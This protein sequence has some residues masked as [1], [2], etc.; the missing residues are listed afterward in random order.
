MIGF[1]DS[2]VGGLSIY[3]AVH[4][5]LPQ[6][7]TMYVG[8]NAHVPYGPRT[9][10][11]VRQFTTEVVRFL[12]SRNANPIIIACNTAS[13]ASLQYLRNEYPTTHFIGL[14]PA[15][16]PAAETTRTGRIGV[17]ATPGTFRGRLYMQVKTQ[18]AS[19]V[20]VYQDTCLGL[21]EEIENGR[22]NQPAARNILEHALRPMIAMNI[23][24]LVLGCTHYPFAAELIR[25]IIGDQIEIIEPGQAIA[26]RTQFIIEN[27]PALQ[28]QE[29]RPPYRFLS[30]GNTAVLTNALECL[31][32]W[33]DIKVEPLVWRNGHQVE[34]A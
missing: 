8:D 20:V 25:D 24:R 21:V 1:F 6:Y 29:D 15:I 10:H 14:V 7:A 31:L 12:I 17:L 3:R 16:K 2:G 32:G 11:Q 5:L 18:F 19:N 30:T 23:D 4:Q 27:N 28:T 9:H 26:R 33:N 34:P 13:S 22:V